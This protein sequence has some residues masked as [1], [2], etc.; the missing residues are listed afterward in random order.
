MNNFTRGE[1]RY[2]EAT[3]KCPVVARIHRVGCWFCAATMT[4]ATRAQTISVRHFL[5]LKWL[6]PSEWGPTRS[7]SFSISFIFGCVMHSTTAHETHALHSPSR[8]VFGDRR[9]HMGHVSLVR[10][11]RI[12]LLL[13]HFFCRMEPSASVI[14]EWK[15]CKKWEWMCVKRTDNSC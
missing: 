5:S 9:N 4:S 12:R 15:T 2:V 11:V 1:K 7:F 6:I 13:I 14:C 8:T 3:E 10:C